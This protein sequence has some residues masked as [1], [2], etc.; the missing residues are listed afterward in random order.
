MP[1]GGRL[2]LR[3]HTLMRCGPD[4]ETAANPV[5]EVEMV[6]TDSGHGMDSAT[7]ARIFESDFTTK[8]TTHAGLGLT[9]VRRIVEE[10]GGTIAVETSVGR[11]STFRLSFPVAAPITHLA[12]VAS[13]NAEYRTTAAS[14]LERNGY[15]VLIAEDGLEAL[16][17]VAFL[18]TPVDLVVV[19]ADLPGTGGAQLVHT[20]RKDHHLAAVLVNDSAAV[21]AAD[22]DDDVTVT[23]R[24]P[25]I[26]AVTACVD[27]LRARALLAG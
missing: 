8:D 9:T 10:S 2:L 7:L 19:D 27:Q 6:V 16:D 11:G 5:R 12:L 25:L 26:A 24:V 3:V 15:R 18:A 20:L 17:L 14:E 1:D 23:A 13:S 4:R 21:T 22:G